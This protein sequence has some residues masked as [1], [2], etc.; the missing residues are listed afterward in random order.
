MKIQIFQR[1]QAETYLARLGIMFP[2]W[3]TT[4]VETAKLQ[5]FVCRIL[6]TRDASFAVAIYSKDGYLLNRFNVR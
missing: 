5:V 1:R 6:D 3:V 4:K 2:L